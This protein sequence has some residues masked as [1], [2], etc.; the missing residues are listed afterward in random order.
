LLLSAET[1][2][3]DGFQMDISRYVEPA[4]VVALN[5][6]EVPKNNRNINKVNLSKHKIYLS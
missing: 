2:N 1:T 5:E 3:I 6:L 4:P